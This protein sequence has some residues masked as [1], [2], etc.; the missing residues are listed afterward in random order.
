MYTQEYAIK[1]WIEGV[2]NAALEFRPII[3]KTNATPSKDQLIFALQLLSRLTKFGGF[4]NEAIEEL[5]AQQVQYAIEH[6]KNKQWNLAQLAA[7]REAIT[8]TLDV[9]YHYDPAIGNGVE[10]QIKCFHK[11]LREI[12]KAY[13]DNT[14]E[15]ASIET[16]IMV[17]EKIIPCCLTPYYKH[18]AIKDPDAKPSFKYISKEQKSPVSNRFVMIDEDFV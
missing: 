2:T 6:V 12:D 14:N 16:R 7:A 9:Y 8:N 4:I 1:K 15:T 3:Y 17:I 18:T 10:Y 13:K 11:T 5:Y